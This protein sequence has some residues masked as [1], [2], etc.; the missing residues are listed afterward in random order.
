MRYLVAVC[1]VAALCSCASVPTEFHPYRVCVWSSDHRYFDVGTVVAEELDA[2][3][4][5]VYV[6]QLDRWPAD[7]KHLN[8]VRIVDRVCAAV[9]MRQPEWPQPA[10]WAPRNR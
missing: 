3:S 1:L 5:R 4:N 6:V 9:S 7:G 2:D 8:R 10:P